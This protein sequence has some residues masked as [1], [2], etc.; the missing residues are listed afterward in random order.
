MLFLKK[1]IMIHTYRFLSI[2]KFQII[3]LLSLQCFFLHGTFCSFAATTENDIVITSIDTSVLIPILLNDSGDYGDLVI[4]SLTVISNPLHGNALKN[5]DGTVTYTPDTGYVGSDSFTYIVEDTDGNISNLAT[6]NITITD[7]VVIFDDDFSFDTTSNYTVENTWTLG[8]TGRFLYDTG[9]QRSLL[10]TGDNVGSMISQ[11]VAPTLSGIFS[12]DFLPTNKYPVAGRI[13][14]LLLQD[15]DNYYQIFSTDGGNTGSLTK[16]VDGVA[17]DTTVF[18]SGYTQNTLYTI[19]V[20]FSPELTSVEAFGQVLSISNDPSDI[21]VNRFSI[22]LSQQDAYL[23]N[24]RLNAPP[25]GNPAPVAEDDTATTGF[26]TPAS[27]SVLAND[28]DLN[29]NIDPTTIVIVMPASEGLALA[30][31]DGT[32]S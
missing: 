7:T 10:L 18:T 22:D 6:V 4:S 25:L 16:Y 28:S 13:V 1:V 32:I 9:N 19:T 15:A 27:I 31:P 17:V 24:I 12:M 2:T 14:L 20:N 8:G 21:V 23:D 29:N 3:V 26:N 11:S 5:S 30:E